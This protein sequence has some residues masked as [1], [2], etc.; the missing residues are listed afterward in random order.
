MK[1]VEFRYVKINNNNCIISKMAAKMAAENLNIMYLCFEIPASTRLLATRYVLNQTY[2]KINQPRK[3]QLDAPCF[4]RR[5]MLH[6]LARV[7]MLRYLVTA[8][9]F[10]FNLLILNN[11]PQYN[12]TQKSLTWKIF[13]RYCIVRCRI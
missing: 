5:D 11:A 2:K 9:L 1:D 6:T 7:Q 8:I 13:S 10:N 3:L 12:V 4:L